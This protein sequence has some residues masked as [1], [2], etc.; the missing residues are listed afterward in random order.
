VCLA[1]NLEID[2]QLSLL[3]KTAPVDEKKGANDEK[4][5]N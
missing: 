1:K 3:K 5:R 4:A 2:A